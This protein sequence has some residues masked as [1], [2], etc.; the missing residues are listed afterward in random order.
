MNPT[1]SLVITT[2][3]REKYLPAAIESIL[4]QT[5]ADFELLIWDDGS[6]D[7][8]V[9][10]ATHYTTFDKRVKVIAA[11][12]TGRIQALKD[13]IA[14]TNGKY[15]GLV[16]S[17]DMLAPTA[18]AETVSILDSQPSYGMVYTDHL[19]TDARGK[20][21]GIGDRCGIPY[22]P[23]RLLIDF[24]TFHFRLMRRSVYEDVGGINSELESAEDYDLC[25]RL[26]EVTEI[27]HHPKPLYLYR[28][29]SESISGAQQLKQILASE[30]AINDALVRRGLANSLELEVSCHG[31]RPKFS[32][33]QKKEPHRAHG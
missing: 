11:P 28:T 4:V 17:D 2:Y 13:A 10:M 32:L 6:S 3:N 16:D 23:E 33:K 9:A 27:Y 24:M 19:V 8:S 21:I 20:V 15:W 5:Y 30:K 18:L 29:H 22:S 7:R 12:H 1:V 14:Q 31:D 25:L 26:S